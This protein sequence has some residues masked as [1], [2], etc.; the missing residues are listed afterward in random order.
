MSASRAFFPNVLKE[1]FPFS[2]VAWPTLE[3]HSSVF[4]SLHRASDA[5]GSDKTLVVKRVERELVFFDVLP[6]VFFRPIDDGTDHKAVYFGVPVNHFPPVG[7]SFG[8]GG[9][10]ADNEF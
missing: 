7:S 8:F 6:D 3:L 4:F 9:S 5:T 10:D 2:F 1:F